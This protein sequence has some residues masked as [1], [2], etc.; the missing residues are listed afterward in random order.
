MT[1]PAPAPR[2]GTRW[3]LLLAGAVLLQL[4]VLYAP[5][6]PSTGETTGIDKVV[7]FSIFALVAW[8]GRRAGLRTGPLV[9]VLLAHAV[10]SEVLQWQLLAHRDG[11]WR[12]SLADA[13]GVAAGALLPV[14]GARSR[15]RMG[16]WRGKRATG[17]PAGR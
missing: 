13:V 17:S 5:R 14:P 2:P 12:D 8:A 6:A 11:D 7:H 16:T 15:G 10:L 4:V 1:T 9:A 3:R